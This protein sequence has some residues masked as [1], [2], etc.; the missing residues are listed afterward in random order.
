MFLC[1][2]A[3]GKQHVVTSDGCHA[4]SL[5]KAPQGFESVHAVGQHT[6]KSWSSMKIDGNDIDVPKEAGTSSGVSSSFHHDEYLVYDEAQVRIR[7]VVTV[8]L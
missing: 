4:S 8:K 6:P 2:S 5:K 3:L 7:Y 1:E